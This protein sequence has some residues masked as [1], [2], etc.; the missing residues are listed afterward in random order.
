[1]IKISN[2]LK[3]FMRENGKYNIFLNVDVRTSCCG[4]AS[5]MDAQLVSEIKE[6]NLNH[7]GYDK[8]E[9]ETGFL[10]YPKGKVIIGRDCKFYLGRML[11]QKRIKFEDV[12]LDFRV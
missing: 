9:T 11:W 3:D 8:A 5:D 6:E 10:Y 12:K 4:I 1:M 2:E 7:Y